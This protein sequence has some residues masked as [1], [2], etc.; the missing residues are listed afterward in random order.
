MQLNYSCPITGDQKDNTTIRVVAGVVLTITTIT[1]LIGLQVSSIL[2][3]TIFGLLAL[4]FIIRGFLLPKY[5][6]LAK[7]AKGL[8]IFLKLG[9]Q[10]VDSGPKIFAARIGVLFTISGT[11]LYLL[12]NITGA[13]IV[14][15]ILLVCAGLE[16]FF[17]FCLGCW[18]YSL[19]P[20]KLG[21][22]FTYRFIR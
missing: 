5:S 14:A 18:M 17:N 9:Q 4:D 19:L 22:I 7:L 15:G 8:V 13:T 3:A 6:P 10:L 20:G 2:A 16:A 11:V 1:I 12:G 21:R